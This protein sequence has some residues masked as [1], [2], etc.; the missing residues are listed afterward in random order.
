[1]HEPSLGDAGAR[2]QGDLHLAVVVGRRVRDL[3]QEQ[4]VSRLGVPATVEVRSGSRQ[5]NVRLRLGVAAQ[6]DR[7]LDPQDRLSTLAL[8]EQL[9]EAPDRARMPVPD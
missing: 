9:G 8:T 1:M 7:V 5:A 4:D 3:D 2:V 6:T